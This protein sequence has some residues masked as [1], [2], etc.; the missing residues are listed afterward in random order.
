MTIEKIGRRWY[1]RGNTYAA[2]DALRDA[3]C[4]WDPDQKAWWTSK[5]D[6]AKKFEGAEATAPKAETPDNIRVIGKARYKGRSYYVRWA[7]V[8][9]YGYSLRL[10]TLDA[11]IDFWASGI[12][13]RTAQPGQQPGEREAVWEKTYQEPKTLG[14]IQR[15]IER[16]KEADER[17]EERCAECGRTGDLIEDLEDGLMKHYNCCDIPSSR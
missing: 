13:P 1:I 16:E 7:G 4:K 12:D 9:K 5:E 6:V 17:G 8:T 15:F 3:G 2:K 10:T 11:K 14:S